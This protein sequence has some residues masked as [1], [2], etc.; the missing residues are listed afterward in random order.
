M[1]DMLY[2]DKKDLDLSE[3]YGIIGSPEFDSRP[4]YKIFLAKW[5]NVESLSLRYCSHLQ[6]SHLDRVCTKTF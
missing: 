2:R 6:A 5:K 4:F 1:V 3:Y